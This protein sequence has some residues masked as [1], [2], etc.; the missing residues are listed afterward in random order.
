MI[1]IKKLLLNFENIHTNNTTSFECMSYADL[2]TQYN[3][4]L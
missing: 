2:T 1:H 4:Q 3:I